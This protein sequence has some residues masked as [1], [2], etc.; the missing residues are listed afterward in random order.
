MDMDENKAYTVEE[1][2]LISYQVRGIIDLQAMLTVLKA[3]TKKELEKT[4]KIKQVVN[5]SGQVQYYVRVKTSE[6][7]TKQIRKSTYEACFDELSAYIRGQEQENQHID[8]L[9]LTELFQE[10]LAYK[11]TITESENTIIRHEQHYRKYFKGTELFDMS[12]CKVDKLS[13]NTF[14][15]QLVKCHNISSK[16]WTN[17][18]TIL[19]GMFEYAM[20]KEYISN[21]PFER[22]KI[23]VKF[24]Q[25]NA[26]SNPKKSALKLD[27]YRDLMIFLDKEYAET[28]NTAA[29]AIKLQ[30][31]TGLRVGELVA[32][33]WTDIIE[34]DGAKYLYI[35]KEEV[36]DKRHNVYRVVE[37]TKTHRDRLVYLVS[38]ALKVLERLYE[39][40]GKFPYICSRKG[41]RLTVTQINYLLTKYANHNGKVVKL[42]HTLRK[43]AASILDC[44]HVSHEEI[45]Q[46]LGHKELSTTEAYLFNVLTKEHTQH[47]M[48]QALREV[49]T[50]NN[51]EISA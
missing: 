16:E 29:L 34:E 1:I 9:T 2:I 19:K 35:T 45:K 8:N 49:I 12:L 3:M 32:L 4:Y 47:L 41:E 50:D 26:K 10:W 11:K 36:K 48:E 28:E 39:V 40:S 42:S 23:T 21:N 14:C 43:T 20:D 51:T 30:V 38:D 7:K 31:L 27:E 25:V 17:V 44:N 46:V 6:G 22:V 37:H 18:K 24:K 5:P 13:L 15:N 33:K